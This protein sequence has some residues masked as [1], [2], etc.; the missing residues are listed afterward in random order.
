MRL[1]FRFVLFALAMGA[2]S[3]PFSLFAESAEDADAERTI[4]F[5]ADVRP[6]LSD[7]C[8]ACHG[9]DANQRMAGLRLDTK[10]GAFAESNGY[11][12]IIPGDAENS[13]LIQRL[14]HEDLYERMPPPHAPRPITEEQIR[15][16][17]DWVRQ[18]AEWEE[19][20]AYVPPKRPA[21]PEVQ[22]ASWAANPIDRFVLARLE[23]EGLE[24]SPDADRRTLIRRLSFDLTG[25]PPTPEE[26]DAFLQD[27]RPDAVEALAD[28]LLSETAY[29]ERMAT[30]W[31]DLVR[32]A[33]TSG[34]HSDENVNVWPYRD[35]VIR[36]FNENMPY[37]RFTREN[38]AGDLLPNATLEQ[39]VASA[40]NRLNQ[41]TAEGG[42]QAKEYHAIYAADRV[43]AVSTVWMGATVGCAQCHDH[44]F[45]PYTA[46]DF[47]SFAAFFADVEE[48]GV[49]RGRS[50]WEPVVELPTAEQ[51]AQLAEI[52]AET[53]RFERLYEEDRPEIASGRARW[54]SG[55]SA[56]LASKEPTD[57][58]WIDDEQSAGGQTEGEWKA[59]AADSGAPVFRGKSSWKQTAGPEELKQRLFKGASRRVTVADGD[60][61][62]VYVWLDP[63][64]PPSAVMVQFHVKN[65]EHRAY[66]G[67]DAISYG[68]IGTTDA[69]SRRRMGDL[70]AL[71][72][73]VRLE[74][75]AE[76]VGLGRGASVNGIAF[77]QF[78]GTV[79]WDETGVQTTVGQT[80]RYATPANVLSA[81][82]A[83]EAVR[84]AAQEETLDRH[85]RSIAPELSL[86][87]SE[88]DGLR[89]RRG[90]AAQA[91]AYCLTTVSGPP[92]V[93]RV[94]ARGNWQDD[95]GE[96]VYPE[97]PSFLPGMRGV[98]LRRATRLDLANWLASREN[99][100]TARAFV[101]R[102]WAVFFDE[103]LSRVL[104]DLGAQGEPPSHAELLDWL[105]VEFMES[106]WNV[107][108]MA[109]LMATSR[110]YRQSS[111]PV[112]RLRETDPY[113]RMLARQTARRL[114]S[115]M[116]RDN[117]LFLSGFLSKKI[118]GPSAKPYQPKGYYSNLNFPKRTYAHDTDEN[119]Y[120]RGLYTHWQ[121]T[122]PHPSMTAFDAPSRQECAAQRP[123]SNTPTQALALL[124][125]PT[126]VEAAKGFAA[127]MMRA[128]AESPSGRIEWAYRQALSRAP[129]PAELETLLSLYAKHSAA[130]AADAES[131]AALSRVG[132]S[133]APEG[134]DAAEL[135]AWTS[136]ARVLL[137]LHETITRY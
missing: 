84:T 89:K 61:F 8:Y 121:R 86:I 112:D 34:Y 119:Q 33:D 4:R 27:T 53:A 14:R 90:E 80:V 31:L 117:A 110:T 11:P 2:L 107:K 58:V 130:Y 25:L 76:S 87:R 91:V 123:R 1:R 73:W 47:Y 71:G 56:K 52:D 108:H 54:E 106:G 10:E 62:Y 81:L 75:P 40:F 131:A 116:V 37:D 82:S 55:A 69:P 42:A 44:K 70:P 35:Y 136:V 97:T 6:I 95:T 135:A 9:P 46:K 122:F 63:V 96:V 43:R 137:N 38:L 103:G 132:L 12:V 94:L 15:V 114:D 64:N 49:Y 13:V 105:A 20:W 68:G 126:Y 124:N 88:L 23:A 93:M 74:I 120:R 92:R 45:D 78:G 7:K 57:W 115:E 113:N 109:R 50:K 66:W 72:E 3:V 101:N 83:H 36:A 65:W 59:V 99:P 28:R 48:L 125:D 18:G 24:P 134:L 128:K 17:E 67:A 5:A 79:Y 118:G 41:T 32:Y 51:A 60:R 104:D 22:N 98:N 102:L 85:Y 127:R 21:V 26:T 111:A 77:T 100:M 19:H 16:L 133:G 29:G 30:H 39:K 129:T